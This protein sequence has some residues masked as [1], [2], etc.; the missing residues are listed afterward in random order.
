L[1]LCYDGQREQIPVHTD[2]V[3]TLRKQIQDLFSDTSVRFVMVGLTNTAL[4]YV[5]FYCLL[6]YAHLAPYISSAIAYSLLVG[7]GFM[8]HHAWTFRS[9]APKGVA[10]AKY[11]TLQMSCMLLTAG[12]TELVFYLYVADPR[13]V[14][15]VTTIIAGF[16]SLVASKLWVFADQHPASRGE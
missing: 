6:S 3:S 14:S 10:F 2:E 11:L 9:T 5:L 13:L 8:L 16:I 12:I 7:V 1:C 15:L 4:Y